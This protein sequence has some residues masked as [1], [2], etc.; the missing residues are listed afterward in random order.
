MPEPPAFLVF[1]DLDGT[2]L[3][4]LTYSYEPARPALRELR[5]RQI[6]LVLASSKTRAELE[7]IRSQLDN[8]EPFVAE[9][10]GAVFVPQGTFNFPL[11]GAILR[12]AY[13]LVEFGT[14]YAK[15]RLAL[16]EIARA[17]GYEL[18]GFGDMSVD[19]I[20]NRTGLRPADAVLAKQREYDEPFV[21]IGPLG[22]GQR[23]TAH[24][25]GLRSV[26]LE[27]EARGLRCISGGRFH[28]LLGLHDKGQA[29]RY[30]IQ[31]YRRQYGETHRFLTIALGD[32][33]NDLPML[34]EAD[35]PVLVKSAEEGSAVRT[36]LPHVIRTEAAGPIGWNKTIL[37]LL[38]SA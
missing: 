34:A 37:E 6:P 19:E 25:E 16:T 12:G 20:V 33:E 30:L 9:N 5:Q 28:H 21:I 27:A 17:A 3:D 22:V 15:L 14:P 11:N 13:Q 7:P 4:R 1:T 26:Q 10:G 35:R 18:R 8:R 38:R 24:I 36:E 31:C 29:C 23:D 32:A 2:L